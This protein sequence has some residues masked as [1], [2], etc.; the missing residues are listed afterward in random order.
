MKKWIAAML[1][2]I[3]L[4]GMLPVNALAVIVSGKI[5]TEDELST[6]KVLAGLNDG[7]G[8]YHNGM[9][10]NASMNA[11]QVSD[12]LDEQLSGDLYS[13]SNV[14]AR[15]QV[16]LYDLENG[17]SQ[18]NS[19]LLTDDDSAEYIEFLKSL[20][21]G[22]EDLRE[23]LLYAYDT[24][25]ESQEII[26]MMSDLMNSDQV[27]DYEKVRYSE[28][29]R[30]AG[31]NI[32]EIRQQVVQNSEA[33]LAQIDQLQDAIDGTT[34]SSGFGM[35]MHTLLDD[36]SPQVET[37][38]PLIV[39]GNANTFASRLG[40]N[41]SV[42]A[43]ETTSVT[44]L[45]KDTIGV[46]LKDGKG[47]P[48]PDGIKVSIRDALGEQ[49]RELVT[50]V[51][52]QG[53]GWVSFNIHDFTFDEEGHV[54]AYIEVDTSAIKAD[55]GIDRYQSLCLPR[56]EILRGSKHYITLKDNDGSPYIYKATLDGYDFMYSE[57][58]FYYTS[59]NDESFDIVVEMRNL[60]DNDPRAPVLVYKDP[61][62]NEKTAKDP[63]P[64]GNVY[65]FTDTWKKIISPIYPEV[66]IRFGSDASNA[67]G[68][69]VKTQKTM[70]K[71]VNSIFEQPTD[72]SAFMKGL[73]GGFGF[74][75]NIPGINR[76]ASLD[77]TP[78][79]LEK[80]M[81]KV[82]V[83]ISG[84]VSVGLGYLPEV[85]NPDPKWK[86][87]TMQ[88]YNKAYKDI[89][90][91]TNLSNLKQH[92]GLLRDCY[93]TNKINWLS[94]GG[95]SVA[96]F[97]LLSAKWKPDEK[98]GETYLKINGVGGVTVSF[99]VDITYQ[100]AIGP[101]P[102]YANLNI[103]LSVGVTLGLNIDLI[104]P[105]DSSER[106]KWDLHADDFTL[107]IRLTISVTLGVGIKGLFS[108]W[109]K[110]AGYIDVALHFF[111]SNPKQI[112]FNITGGA[113]VSAGITIL[114][115]SF[116]MEIWR[117]GPWP[118]YSYPA[119]N[120]APYSL[121]DHY[122]SNDG[123]EGG[124]P[125][126]NANLVPM[127]P[128]TY[129]DLNI[130]KSEEISKLDD[131][132]DQIKI[133]TLG[134]DLYTF[135]IQN[136][137]LHW[138]NVTM[139]VS[140]SIVDAIKQGRQLYPSV[141]DSAYVVGSVKDYDFDVTTATG[142]YSAKSADYNP[143]TFI[144]VAVLC[145]G[146]F[147][148]N[149]YPL[150]V[151]HNACLYTMH[152]WRTDNGGLSA[153]M[154]DNR[155][156]P[157]FFSWAWVG[158]RKG[159]VEFVGAEPVIELVTS[160]VNVDD[161]NNYTYANT[162]DVEMTRIQRAYK[163]REQIAA[164]VSIKQI[165]GARVSGNKPDLGSLKVT[166]NN[167]AS[168]DD[169]VESG[170]GDGYVRVFH[171]M[172]P[173]DSWLAVSRSEQG[174]GD[175]GA[176]EFYDNA[177]DAAGDDDMASIVLDETNTDGFAQAVIP[178][179]DDKFA[180]VIFYTDDVGTDG[181]R[182]RL[183]S[184]Y[185]E[186]TDH[187]DG[188]GNLE[189]KVSATGYDIDMP[190][191]SFKQQTIAGLVNLYW[192][193]TVVMRND[194][195]E[196]YDVYRVMVAVYDQGTNTLSNASVCAEFTMPAEC[197]VI[198][199]LFLTP[200]GK[201]YLTA[202]PLPKS[203]G[204]KVTDE[205]MPIWLYSFQTNFSPVMDVKGLVFDETLVSPG[206]FD[207]YSVSVMNSGNMGLTQFEMEMVLH[208][209]SKETVVGALHAD[210]LNPEL[211]WMKMGN[212]V[213][214]TGAKA[215][216]RLFD[217]DMTPQRRDWVVSEKNKK[218]TVEGG[219]LKQTDETKEQFDYV[220]TDVLLP[221]SLA[222]FRSTMQIPA[223]W[224]G[225]KE[226]E[227]RFSKIVT[228]SNWVGLMAR[229]A[230]RNTI[231]A[232]RNGLTANNPGVELTYVRD[233]QTGKM[234]LQDDG[235]ATNALVKNGLVANAI[236]QPESIKARTMHDLRVSHRVYMG[237]NDEKWLSIS[238]FDYAETGESIKLYAEMYLDD[239]KE[240]LRLA[241]PYYEQAVSDGKTHTYDMPLSALVDPNAYRTARVVIQGVGI[242]DRG[243]A[244]NE[245]T[246]YLDGEAGP[247]MIIS[248]PRDVTCKV[249]ETATFNV[250]ASGGATPYHYQWQVW[251]GKEK[252]WVDLKDAVLPTL[253]VDNVTMAMSGRKARCIV[254][255]SSG[256]QIISDAATLTV[257]DPHPVDTGDHSNLPL[258]SAVALAALALLWL[259]RRRARQE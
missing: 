36:G 17:S 39:T 102:F 121:L 236:R 73:S 206:E 45:G 12:W 196:N 147:D 85:M 214:S 51:T 83:D 257:I 60:E 258:Y 87:K 2:L 128:Q 11:R 172:G 64:K 212:D 35:W 120:A 149:S 94:K 124:E 81:P 166:K 174:K 192:L 53:R 42:L 88:Q 135:Y 20:V 223:S 213:V 197:P 80:W 144:T 30:Q 136:G 5:L 10:P 244:D 98:E 31:G 205:K 103:N 173:D 256:Q 91:I 78:S 143:G 25:D 139:N 162:V 239:A 76:L 75:F 134:D 159:L 247:L 19:N 156:M 161:S 199:E 249:G 68:Q 58:K 123:E 65:T 110:G 43:N 168:T 16:A 125:E 24:V 187:K 164:S 201:G 237:P 195:G 127:G 157:G 4:V 169:D 28:R 46:V 235:R 228:N 233:P 122:M 107:D 243:L 22:V 67:A 49:T 246:L 44:V 148:D 62:G 250:S 112:Q 194:K 96:V 177:M 141:Y 240:P 69:T 224:D 116:S 100:T 248:Q 189:L 13:L 171:R 131:T 245:F 86:S 71:P 132:L 155:D 251:M 59:A 158:G 6:Y 193:S 79:I 217:F 114:F 219:K 8:E 34:H 38:A 77:L 47:K 151:E 29:I 54:N 229:A 113:S 37:E 115:V 89:Q 15:A 142:A 104:L 198:R 106:I 126:K 41:N 255:D 160:K 220:T 40:A 231:S 48:A 14:L 259:L 170:A 178:V 238:F 129:P 165:N 211:C 32:S 207:D 93:T 7:A 163:K 208:E 209:G 33:W 21:L 150:E 204:K 188:Q 90:K 3:M 200:T 227:V 61:K 215:F 18:S 72:M 108:A 63:H 50:A 9:R 254:S 221:G 183:K 66:Y 186:P 182:Y 153:S 167:T 140:G 230:K 146:S 55:T 1:T 252:G 203:I 253:E 225:T 26:R 210:C 84:T 70:L 191:D 154:N 222:A 216:K 95:V 152:L 190:T 175:K 226:L 185:L 232:S 184:L 52:E 202:S 179:K 234:V 138:R 109:V 137:R 130:D 118:L 82:N 105:K 242:E 181:K 23:T 176:I 218:Y 74:S 101:V 119:N 145:A 57:Y 241:L 133:A 180:R 97:G 56:E 117:G 27:Y 111:R 99:Y 92:A